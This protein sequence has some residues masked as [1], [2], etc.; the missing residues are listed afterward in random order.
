MPAGS[1]LVDLFTAFTRLRDVDAA[2]FFFGL[3]EVTVYCEGYLCFEG[4]TEYVEETILQGQAPY[5]TPTSIGDWTRMFTVDGHTLL[6]YSLYLYEESDF[7]ARLLREPGND[8]PHCEI[9]FTEEDELY[10]VCFD[11][12]FSR[13]FHDA[14]EW[15]SH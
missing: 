13:I 12:E 7:V 6:R 10:V 15:L 4:V 5:R 9:H 2:S 14:R 11:A 8:K 1:R 3:W